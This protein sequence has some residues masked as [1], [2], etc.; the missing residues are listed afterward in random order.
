MAN[1][2]EN[3]EKYQSSCSGAAA[4]N[5]SRTAAIRQNKYYYL[6]MIPGFVLVLLFCYVPMFGLVM[7]FQNF[8][9]L[10]GFT[11]SEFV[12]LKNFIKIFTLPDFLLAIKNTV[13]YSCVNLF[14]G[15]PLPVFLALMLNEL[16]FP[17]FKRVIQTVSYLPHFL[18][19]VS[20]IGMFYSFFALEGTFNSIRHFLLGPNVENI[21]ILMD[22]R[23][24]LPIIYLSGQWKNIGWSSILYLAAISGIDGTLY[25]AAE[26]DGCGRWKKMRYITIPGILP[27]FTIVFIMAT[28]SLVNGNFEQ[29]FGFQNVYIQDKTEIINTLVY[30]QGIQNGKYSLTTALGLAQGVVSFGLVYITNLITKKLGGGGIW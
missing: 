2:L 12:G 7:A 25:E 6:M 20:V 17:K 29:V 22:S 21:N 16:R 30:R 19:W 14:L 11:G 10:K 3:T 8:D 13:I 9:I 26:I 4:V 18:S 1:N 27:T 24:F 23:Y 5:H 28:A 15:A